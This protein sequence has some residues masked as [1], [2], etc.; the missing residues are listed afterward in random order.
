MGLF[1]QPFSRWHRVLSLWPQ[2]VTVLATAACVTSS[3]G[4]HPVDAKN[5]R[6]DKG[7][8][9]SKSSKSSN[10]SLVSAKTTSD[11]LVTSRSGPIPMPFRVL[12]LARHG[13]S[14]ANALGRING[15]G[16]PDDL[17]EV[18]YR[19]RVGLFAL[20]AHEPI[21]A[22]YVSCLPRTRETA[23]PIAAQKHLE[24]RPRR[25]LDEFSGG[26]FEGICKD[27]FAPGEGPKQCDPGSHDAL[28]RLGARLLKREAGKAAKHPLTYRAPG[29]GESIQDVLARLRRFLV[30]LPPNLRDK[31]VLLVGHGGTN[32]FLLGLL[33][34]LGPMRSRKIRQKH[35]QVFRITRRNAGQSPRVELWQNGRWHMC[36]PAL[37]T[38]GF[39]LDCMA[40]SRV[41][42]GG[43]TLSQSRKSPV[44]VPGR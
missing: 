11:R 25:E 27:L 37:P 42:P 21:A 20:L 33:V 28:S 10:P 13:Q 7:R 1:L 19:Q 43:N 22:V 17:D 24:I 23:A 6:C 36:H 26:I 9:S 16:L 34:G 29:G 12:Y 31:T 3:G 15:A 5:G 30:S 44:R 4:C 18:G 38:P 8:T 35:D 39:G 14:R 40:P 32:R 41:A 2:F